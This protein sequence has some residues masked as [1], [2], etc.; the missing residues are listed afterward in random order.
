MGQAAGAEFLHFGDTLLFNRRYD[1]LPPLGVIDSSSE[2]DMRARIPQ[3]TAL[4]LT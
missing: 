1:I 4:S 3:T 2:A